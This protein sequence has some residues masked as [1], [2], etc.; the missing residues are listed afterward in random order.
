MAMW[1]V[2]LQV[3]AEPVREHVAGAG[4]GGEHQGGR[5]VVRCRRDGT[6]LLRSALLAGTDSPQPLPP[7][8]AGRPR[9]RSDPLSC[10]R[11]TAREALRSSLAVK[12]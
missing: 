10:F 7:A 12:D 9:F 3:E 4:R 5:G 11:E 1:G 6:S 2:D 8:L